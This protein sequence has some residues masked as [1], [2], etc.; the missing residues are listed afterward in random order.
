[1]SR[2]PFPTTPNSWYHL[3]W[4]DEVPRGRALY[5]RA[6]ETELVVFRGEDGVAAVLDAHCRRREGRSSPDGR[7]LGR[8]YSCPVDGLVFDGSGRCVGAERPDA[9]PE[10]RL[11]SWPVCEKNGM[12]FVYHHA[13]GEAPG[14]ALPDVPELASPRWLPVGRLDLSYRSHVQEVVE[15]SVDLGH[16]QLLHNFTGH[17]RLSRFETHAHTFT[18]KVE[19]PKLVFGVSLPADL[20]IN[21]HGMGLAIGRLERP[22]QFMS[23]VT[24]L[25]LDGR[26]I[27]Q[28]LAMFVKAPRIPVAV[29]VLAAGLRWHVRRDLADE[30]AVLEHKRY[31]ERPVI[32][33]DDGPIMKVRRWCRQF[34]TPSPEALS[35]SPNDDAKAPLS[36]LRSF[37]AAR[38]Y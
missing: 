2:F 35:A 33:A 8:C 23:L 3:A 25:P 36:G 38:L 17:A 7:V 12:I 21:Y 26:L 31:L 24:C 9:A 13:A 4:S 28:R 20:T 29:H 15:N 16:F 14:F 22:F 32:V 11:R 10:P 34:Y 37:T 19:A 5:V 18:V 1:M 30:I 27:R 6:F